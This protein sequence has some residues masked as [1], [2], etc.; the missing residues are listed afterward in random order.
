MYIPLYS[1]SLKYPAA[2]LENAMICLSEFKRVKAVVLLVFI[3]SDSSVINPTSLIHLVSSQ[4]VFSS[5]LSQSESESIG[6]S[7][8]FAMTLLTASSRETSDNMDAIYK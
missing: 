7:G 6:S 2:G 8:R 5:M 3:T 1:L 4:L